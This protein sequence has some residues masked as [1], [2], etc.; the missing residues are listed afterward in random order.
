MRKSI[1]CIIALICLMY[2]LLGFGQE[3]KI[4]DF[5]LSRYKVF[6]ASLSAD[7]SKYYY[8]DYLSY[9][10]WLVPHYRSMSDTMQYDVFGCLSAERSY[11]MSTLLFAASLDMRHYFS[12]FFLHGRSDIRSWSSYY[13]HVDPGFWRKT[14]YGD[15]E[16]G[17]GIGHLREGYFASAALHINEILKKEDIIY[18]DLDRK[19][20]LEIAQLIATKQGH[21]IRYDRYEKFMFSELQRIIEDDPACDNSI[22]AYALFKIF[23]IVDRIY[24]GMSD[25][26]VYWSR[27]FGARLSFDLLGSDITDQSHGYGIHEMRNF[28]LFDSVYYVPGIRTVF[29][30]GNPLTLK[31][32]IMFSASHQVDWYDSVT[33]HD[34]R[35][36]VTYAHGIIDRIVFIAMADINY[37]HTVYWDTT[38]QG[39]F[40]ITPEVGLAYYIEDRLRLGA[41]VGY[42][43]QLDGEYIDPF[44]YVIGHAIMFNMSTRWY[45]F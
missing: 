5:R 42:D 35:T 10:L 31:S 19:T 4:S 26:V 25:D 41:E 16:V 2:I 28:P 21:I 32:H 45:I 40:V 30:Y 43:F 17:C 38:A 27:Q 44:D 20:L 12:S 39:R 6:R 33:S 7:L 37:Y 1:I 29:E 14:R 9:N 8:D 13:S 36:N 23:D 24:P 11:E 3:L 15:L 22:S 34:L 18:R